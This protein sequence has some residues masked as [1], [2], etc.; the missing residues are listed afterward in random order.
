[1]TTMLIGPRKSRSFQLLLRNLQADQITGLMKGSPKRGH[2]SAKGPL[3]NLLNTHAAR[4]VHKPQ[5]KIYAMLSLSTDPEYTLPKPDYKQP[6]E[7]VYR[8]TTLNFIK[9]SWNLDVLSHVWDPEENSVHPSWV[10]SC[11]KAHRPIL[12]LDSTGTRTMFRS[13]GSSR[14]KMNVSEDLQTLK[15]KGLLIYNID[16]VSGLANTVKDWNRSYERWETF[17]KMD[18]PRRPYVGGGDFFKAFWRTLVTNKAMG[19]G[20]LLPRREGGGKG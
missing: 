11:D 19:P 10:P 17:A 14:V 4:K 5:D 1:M 8:Q 2:E 13:A 15:L 16:S 9:H 7:E 3:L 12:L 18:D 6:F 20:A